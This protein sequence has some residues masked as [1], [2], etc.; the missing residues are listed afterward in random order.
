LEGVRAVGAQF[1]GNPGRNAAE[2]L[3]FG[4]G[5]A[6]NNQSMNERYLKWYTP[7]LSREF[8]MLAFG[9][10]GGLP[11]ILYPRFGFRN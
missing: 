9:N 5:F 11:L 7:W 4:S 6:R 8:E 1:L 10:G 2:F 3:D